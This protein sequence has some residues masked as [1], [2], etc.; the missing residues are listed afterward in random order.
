MSKDNDGKLAELE[1]T[2]L[3]QQSQYQVERTQ[4]TKQIDELR[5]QLL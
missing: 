1:K 5:V 4:L 2:L 3:T